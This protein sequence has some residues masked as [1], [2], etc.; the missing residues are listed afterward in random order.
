[1]WEKVPG[2]GAWWVHY[3]ENGV[4]HPEKA[5]RKSDAVALYQKRKSDIRAGVKL[6]NSWSLLLCV[7][8]Q[9]VHSPR[10]IASGF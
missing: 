1:M 2:F 5:R 9:D 7:K 6:P 4:L 8:S 10:V 3:R